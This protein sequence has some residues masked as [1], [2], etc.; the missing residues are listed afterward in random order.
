MGNCCDARHAAP[1]YTAQKRTHA[2]AT[3]SFTNIHK[4]NKP[5][6]LDA[7]MKY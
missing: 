6:I 1:D 3:M 4:D 7:V 2:Q 5:T